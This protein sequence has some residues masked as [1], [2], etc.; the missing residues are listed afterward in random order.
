M[1]LLNGTRTHIS[2]W[3]WVPDPVGRSAVFDVKTV[4]I[5]PVEVT[6]ST[7]QWVMNPQRRT[8][9]SS[10]I[11]AV[12]NQTYD[13]KTG[14]I[15]VTNAK[16]DFNNTYRNQQTLRLSLCRDTRD[17]TSLRM[18][19]GKQSKTLFGSGGWI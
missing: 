14:G 5:I 2:Q 17:P 1:A 7:H 18:E 10:F 8:I 13:F 6:Y 12:S 11:I 15:Q 19:Y 3:C 9:S 16:S 4:T